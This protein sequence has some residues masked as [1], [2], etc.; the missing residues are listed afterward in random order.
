MRKLMW[1]S[2]GFLAACLI[3]ALFLVD[4]WLIAGCAG[5]GVLFVLC[6]VLGWKYPWLNRAA[7]VCL[8]LSLGLGWFHVYSNVQLEPAARLDG[9][10]MTLQIQAMDY[11]WDTG[12]GTAVDGRVTIGAFPCKVRV[13]LNGTPEMEPGDVILG[14]FLMEYA[15]PGEIFRRANGAFLTVYQSS[16]ARLAKPVELPWLCYPAQWRQEL[17]EILEQSFPED[18]AAFAK[19]LLLGERADLDYETS[20]AFRLSGISH[21]VAVSGLH[22]TILFSV[23]FTLGLHRRF[24]TALIGVPVLVLFAAVAGFTP[25]INRAC[26]MQI[27]MIL[28]Y[29][30]EKDYDRPTALSFA[31]LVMMAANPLIVLSISFQLSVGCMAGILLFYDGISEW[32]RK[33]MPRMPA[34]GLAMSLAAISLTTPLAALYFGCVSL[35]G[36]LTNLL[37]LW[38]VTFIFWGILLVCILALFWG[39]GAAGLAW[40]ISWPIR[41]VLAVAKVLSRFPLAAVYTCNEY[42]VL[43]LAFLYVLLGIFV[44]QRRKQPLTLLC[45][46]ILGLVMALGISWA[47]LMMDDCRVTVLDVGQGQCILLQSEGRTWMVDCGGS[48]DEDTADLAADTLLSQGVTRLDGLILTHYDR[49]HAGAA[50]YLLTRIPADVVLLPDMPDPDGAGE[51][52][53]QRADN[54][55]WVDKDLALN[56]GTTEMTIFAP[57]KG[58]TGNESSLCVLFQAANCDILITGDRTA[59][60]ELLLM[61]KAE[62]PQLEILVAGHHGSANSTSQELLAATDPAIVAISVGNNPYGQPA[63]ALLERLAQQG[64]AVYQTKT[65]GNLIFRR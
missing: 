22:V 30:L 9:E 14:E 8:G 35:V 54:A 2:L 60:G 40:A 10:T 13:Y 59:L 12:Y 45:C 48:D 63:P 26:I 17:M 62:L 28:A 56:Y 38:V 47:E 11:G 24:L 49:D 15:Q 46:G 5:W 52:I 50:E 42:V 43:W 55:V 53:A 18:T 58:E 32:L 16:D 41:Y 34:D 20:T 39:G 25:S 57:L 3:C 1:F 29:C 21:V 7:A 31:A 27:L 19:A 4:E 61:R 37:I 64:C 44:V 23:V 36:V 6:L 65:D 51:K 33:Y